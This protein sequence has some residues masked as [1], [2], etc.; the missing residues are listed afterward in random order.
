MLKSMQLKIRKGSFVCIIGEVGS[1]KT[2]L[3]STMLGDLHYMGDEF[4]NEHREEKI[5]IEEQ[6]D[7][8][9]KSLREENCSHATFPILIGQEV[10]FV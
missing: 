3:L 6:F 7:E 5:G 9:K 4:L 2:S 8:I 1:G 10:A